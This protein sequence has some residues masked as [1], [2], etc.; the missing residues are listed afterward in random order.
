MPCAGT[1]VAKETGRQTYARYVTRKGQITQKQ[2]Y[3][4]SHDTMFLQ[5]TT[6]LVI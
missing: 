3:H 1:V 4:H 5:Y 2:R 6:A